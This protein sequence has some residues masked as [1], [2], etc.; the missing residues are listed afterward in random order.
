M[1]TIFK[2]IKKKIVNFGREF[3]SIKK[4]QMKT[5]ELKITITKINSIDG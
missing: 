2:E 3:K 4:I 5:L 1:L